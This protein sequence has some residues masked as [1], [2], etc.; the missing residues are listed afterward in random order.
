MANNIVNNYSSQIVTIFQEVTKNY[1]M[2]LNIIKQAEAEL[3]DL[4]HEAELSRPKDMYQGYLLYKA[5]RETRIRRRTAKIENE[6][7]KDMYDYFQSQHGQAFKNKIQSIQGNAVKLKATQEA[8]TYTP[9]QRNNLTI[10]NRHSD[11]N[12]PFEQML[13]EFK[14]NKAYM[15]NGKLRK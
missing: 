11:A 3:N 13:T 4:A 14:K 12:K 1:E 10:T 7:L 6:L 2:N 15:K 9:K 5:I 8:R